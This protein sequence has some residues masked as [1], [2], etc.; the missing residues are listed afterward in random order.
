MKL[1]VIVSYGDIPIFLFPICT[2]VIQYIPLPVIPIPD[3]PIPYVLLLYIP[4]PVIPIPDIPT[5][6]V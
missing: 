3:I 1:N 4:L 5:R 6:K 2:T